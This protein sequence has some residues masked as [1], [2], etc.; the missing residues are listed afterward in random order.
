MSKSVTF[1]LSVEAAPK[2]IV[3]VEPRRGLFN[4]DLPVV[5]QY[6]ELLYFL[7]WRE[8]KVRYK[9]T[10]IGAAW[11]ILQ[12]LTTMLI[13]TVIFGTF[14]KIPSDGLPYPIFAY[15]GLLPWTYFSEATVRSSASLVGDANL[16]RKVYFPRLLIPLSAAVT[17]V[18][19]FSLAFLMLL[20][21]MVWYGFHP[22][23]NALYIPLFLLLAF[24]TALA[25]GLW[26]SALNVKYRDVRHTVPFLVQ[27]WM[28]ASPVVYPMSIVPEK[29]RLFFALNPMTGVI[30]GF[31]WGLLG[32]DSPDFGVMIASTIVVILL[33]FS[34]L[35]FFRHMERT[36]ADVV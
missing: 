19:D 16:I 27:I 12:P 10:V 13:F 31:R 35:V 5:W 2:P 25:V 9:Q 14:A 8:V 33:L 3:V 32:K 23:W 30:E 34:G 17:P 7:A 24:S 22:T 18:V 6:R 4:L 15:A 21:M 36:F 28:Y 26:L 20:G 1:K 11:A 29:W